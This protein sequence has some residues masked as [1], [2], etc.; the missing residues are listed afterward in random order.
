MESE[1]LYLR[2]FLVQMCVLFRFIQKVSHAA[3]NYCQARGTEKSYDIISCPHEIA[4]WH[5][6]LILLPYGK[7]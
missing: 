2:I 1:L 4:K 3:R 6:G 5:R 7:P